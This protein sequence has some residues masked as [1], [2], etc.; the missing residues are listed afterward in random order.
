MSY[1]RQPYATTQMGVRKD[2]KQI[3]AERLELR[4]ELVVIGPMAVTG[5]TVVSVT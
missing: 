2:L 1:H 4:G 3:R 5:T